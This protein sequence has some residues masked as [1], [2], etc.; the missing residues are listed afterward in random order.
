VGNNAINLDFW[1]P[2][3]CYFLL[4]TKESKEKKIITRQREVGLCPPKL[5]LTT[6]TQVNVVAKARGVEVKETRDWI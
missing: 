2:F 4:A 6:E 5:S 1:A 3:L